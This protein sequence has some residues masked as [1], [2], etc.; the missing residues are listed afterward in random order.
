MI[1][2]IAVTIVCLEALIFAANLWARRRAEALLGSLRELKVGI[3]PLESVQPL[4]I[5]YNAEKRTS[6][7]NCASADVAYGI[8][9]SNPIIDRVGPDHPLLLRA[10]LRP[11]GAIAD[12]SFNHGYLCEYIYGIGVLLPGDRYPLDPSRANAPLVGLDAK[13]IMRTPDNGESYH[14]SA[15]QTLLRGYREVGVRIGIDVSVTPSATPSELQHALTYDLS[16]LASF[17]GCRRLSQVMPLAFQD[18]IHDYQTR[19]LPVPEEFE[20]E[21]R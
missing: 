1:L 2:P 21:G 18:A 11:W 17:R 15:F 5:A 13:T 3:S 9:V 6:G 7:T 14:V 19:G 8:R 10:G 20:K 12:L 16:C 4:L